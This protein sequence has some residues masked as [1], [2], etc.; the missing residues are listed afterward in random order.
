MFALVTVWGILN[1]Q[2]AFISH[3]KYYSWGRQK[4]NGLYPVSNFKL[5]LPPKVSNYTPLSSEFNFVWNYLDNVVFFIALVTK[6]PY[7]S[8]DSLKKLEKEVENRR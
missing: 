3:E 2:T 6:T 5:L 8:N 7:K 1:V 4:D